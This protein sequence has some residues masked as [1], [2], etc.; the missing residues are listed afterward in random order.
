MRVDMF[1]ATIARGLHVQNRVEASDLWMPGDDG[2][3]K[4]AV[5]SGEFH[6]TLSIVLEY[7]LDTV[8]A[9][10]AGAVVQQDRRVPFV[11]AVRDYSRPLAGEYRHR[12]GRIP[13]ATRD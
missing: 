10:T 4:C 2:P 13:A 12:A 6:C 8:S 11:H 5:E 1:C 9:K 7:E 3:T